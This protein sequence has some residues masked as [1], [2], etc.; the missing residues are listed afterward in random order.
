MNY[1][2]LAKANTLKCHMSITTKGTG[3]RC[4]SSTVG[5]SEVNCNDKVNDWTFLSSRYVQVSVILSGG[6]SRFHC[7][8]RGIQ[9]LSFGNP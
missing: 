8:K 2:R 7:T 4:W 9:S 6:Y 3:Q 1:N 5:R